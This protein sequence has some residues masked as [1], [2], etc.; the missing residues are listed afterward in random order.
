MRVT[1][2]GGTGHVGSYLVPR[3]VRLGHDVT[4]VTRSQRQPYFADAAWDQVQR[5]TMDR[6]AEE[7]AGRFGSRI[8]T[9][10]SDVVID[11]ICFDPDSARD[12]AEALRGHVQHFI[13]CGTI[14]VHGPSAE[15]PTTEEDNRNPFGSYGEKKKAIED[16]LLSE[17][18]RGGF[19]ATVIHP[20]H[21]TG[22]GWV[23]INPAGNLDIAVFE[24]LARGEEIVLP[25]LGMETL[26]HVHAD[27]VAGLM[28]AAV[29][30]RV[31]AIGESF[32]AVSPAALSLRG[33]AQAVAR[34]FGREAR[35]R[36]LP[37][38]EFEKLVGAEAARLTWDHIA[39][40]PNCAIDKAKQLLGFVPRHTSMDAVRDAL[41]WLIQQGRLNP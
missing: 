9:L 39:H 32:H 34:E 11:M 37:W 19:P 21:I 5:I 3:L 41:A 38:D 25:N 6:A 31:C 18:R 29:S 7:S 13:H 24:R 20:G 2:I 36:F 26:H 23:P 1:I 16:Y 4:C 27:D 22:R 8:R 10:G 33:Y 17:A 12:L 15:V 14:W 28:I 35:L 40:S 30:R